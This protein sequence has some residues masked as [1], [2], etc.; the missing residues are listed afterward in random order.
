[1][2]GRE[3]E[4]SVLTKAALLLQH[5]Q[6]N[7]DAHDRDSMLDEALKYNQMIWSIFQGELSKPDNPLPRKLRED[8]LSLSLFIDRR[9]FEV[10]S[11]PAVEKLNAIININLNLA[12]G[13]R[14]S[15]G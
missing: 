7:W 6:N 8:I 9:I 10:M 2:S 12:A 14:G 3:I 4:A 11:F 1:M 5:C 13:L 15:A